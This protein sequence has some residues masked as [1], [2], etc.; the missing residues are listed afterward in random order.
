MQSNKSVMLENCRM[1]EF[2]ATKLDNIMSILDGRLEIVEE[3]HSSDNELRNHLINSF[4]GIDDSPAFR[5]AIPG[6]FGQ[7]GNNADD[8][9]AMVEQRIKDIIK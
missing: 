7:Y 6:H 9:I 4:K 5:G 1:L 2:V 3:I 8:R